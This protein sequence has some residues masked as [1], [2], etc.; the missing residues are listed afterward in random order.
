[1][2]NLLIIIM[3]NMIAGMSACNDDPAESIIEP[4]EPTIEE[5]EAKV[6]ENCYILEEAIEAYKAAS[7]YCHPG[8]FGIY[9]PSVSTDPYDLGITLLEFLPDGELLENPFTGERT[10]P[11]TDTVATEPG[12]IGY[13]VLSILGA[14]QVYAITGCGEDSLVVLLDNIRKVESRVMND[15]FIVQS[16]LETYVEVNYGEKTYDYSEILPEGRLLI[17]NLSLA[18]TNPIDGWANNQ[19]EIGLVYGYY[20]DDGSFHYDIT[21]VGVICPVPICRIHLYRGELEVSVQFTDQI[22]P[23]LDIISFFRQ[24]DELSDYYE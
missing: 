2:R 13:G 1:M 6:I 19:G 21:G 10:E 4:S 22:I 24:Y 20:D 17:N 7:V 3:I 14:N 9:P 8:E 11:S 23:I 18:R 16:S 12:Q 15:C 5:L